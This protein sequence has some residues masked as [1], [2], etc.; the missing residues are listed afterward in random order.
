MKIIVRLIIVLFLTAN[1]S[2]QTLVDRF[3]TM[4]NDDIAARLNNFGGE[5]KNA[6]DSKGLV[7]M[8]FAAMVTPGEFARRLNGARK[9]T[10]QISGVDIERI[11]TAAGLSR[12]EKVSYELW[13]ILPDGKE[14]PVFSVRISDIT[15]KAVTKKKLFDEQC[16][17]CDT[18]PYV[19]EDILSDEGIDYYGAALKANP[20]CFASIEIGIV[21]GTSGT[22]AQRRKLTARILKSLSDKHGINSKRVNIRFNNSGFASFYIV[23]KSSK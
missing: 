13:L 11:E 6:P 1:I 3:D 21:R 4:I 8:H 22:S 16:I 18:S 14:P 2:A 12:D 5:L 9:F 23:P 15:A 7:V 17:D 19:S 10:A 20:E